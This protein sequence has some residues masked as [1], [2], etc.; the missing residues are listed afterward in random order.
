V[1]TSGQYK[2]DN[3]TKRV[4]VKI[5]VRQHAKTTVRSEKKMSDE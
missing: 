2:N 3:K 4:S 1:D 5:D